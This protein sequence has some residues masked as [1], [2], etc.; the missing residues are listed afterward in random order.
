VREGDDHHTKPAV[1]V[2]PVVRVVPV[3]GGEEVADFAA[4]NFFLLF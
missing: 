1:V 4:Y 3:A 2:D